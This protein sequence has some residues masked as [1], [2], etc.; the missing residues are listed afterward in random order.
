MPTPAKIAEVAD[1]TDRLKRSRAAVLMHYREL[2]VK[3]ITD[4]RNRLRSGG[5]EI[6][7][8][9]AKNTLLRIAANNAGKPGLEDLF[10]GPTAVAFI[11]SDEPKGAK[12][13]ADAIRALRKENVKVTG[14]V[15]GSQGLDPAGVERLGTME[16]RDVQL[17][18]LLGAMQASA[19][20]LAATLNGAAQQLVYT[21]MAYQEKLQ[22]QQ[23]G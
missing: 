18:K 6:E 16:P 23:Q 17:A 21:L 19:S 12:A 1:L 10:K 13:V 15:I 22:A 4:L 3:E 14:G 9:V 8:R 7:L 5:N 11:Y 2:K 20:Q